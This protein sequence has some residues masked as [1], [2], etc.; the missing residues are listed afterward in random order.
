MVR[1]ISLGLLLASWVVG[2]AARGA[3]AVLPI[4]PVDGCYA[5]IPL[6]PGRS[7][8]ASTQTGIDTYRPSCARGTARECAF[9]VDVSAPSEL[10]AMLETSNFDGALALYEQDTGREL[11]CVDDAP[12]GDTRHARLERTLSPG[13]Y[14]L[15]VD[16]ANGEAGDFQLFTELEPL[17]EPALVCEAA[18]PLTP[19]T[20]LRESTRGGRHLFSG[21]C[22][23]GEGPEHV[24]RIIVDEPSRIRV[25]QQSEYDGSLYLRADCIDPRSELACNDDFQGHARSLLTARLGPGSYFLISDSYARDQS[26]DYVLAYERVDEPPPL[27]RADRCRVFGPTVTAGLHEIDTLSAP[28]ALSGS[29]G[30]ADAPELL[31]PLRI[32]A[33]T[34]LVALLEA[35]EFNAVLYLRRACDDAASELT[36]W[37]APRI[38]GITVPAG[39]PA[40]IVPLEPGRY[41][42]VIDGLKAGDLGA[43][44]LHVVLEPLR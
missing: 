1:S 22:G 23:G 43:A 24:H 18:R 36:C 44:T 27:Q 13:R 40:M 31:L 34:T 15:V 26:G 19:G 8:R 29:C 5:P 32:D 21:S 4:A 12:P 6:V 30:G 7:L 37:T 35:P 2:C 10:R 28:S 9:T 39:R 41:V 42:L 17:P 11:R 3:T 33:P 38:D 16:G 25:R 14:Q 20:T